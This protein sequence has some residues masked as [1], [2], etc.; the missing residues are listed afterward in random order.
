MSKKAEYK[1]RIKDMPEDER[2]RERLI[3][4]G[5]KHLSTA[6][7]LAIILRVGTHE[8]NAVDFAKELLDKYNLPSLAKSNVIELRKTLGVG[9]AKACQ[10]IACFELGRRLLT[11]ESKPP[12]KTAQDVADLFMPELQYLKKENFKGVYLDS[13]NRVIWDETISIGTLNAS[14]VHPREV[15]STALVKSANAIILVHNHPSGDPTPSSD[16][17]E[18]TKKMID[19]GKLMDIEVLDHIIIGEGEYVSLKEREL[20]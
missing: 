6:E 18:I 20:I 1:V 3:K 2:P 13:K 11:Y 8:M 16:D 9:D 7:L 17:I 10:I 14:I 15:F 4:Y 19:A 5:P 12:I